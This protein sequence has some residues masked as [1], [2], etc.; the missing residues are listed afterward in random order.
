MSELKAGI[1]AYHDTFRGLVSVRVVDV[2]KVEERAGFKF[3]E[4][5]VR[6][7]NDDV[8]GF[9]RGEVYTVPVS[10]LVQRRVRVDRDGHLKVRGF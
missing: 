10:A 9:P 3:G 1:L 7:T 2:S 6:T 5:T 4:V 8:P